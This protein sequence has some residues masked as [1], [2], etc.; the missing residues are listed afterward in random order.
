[1][2]KK[3]QLINRL[4]IY[5]I[6]IYSSLVASAPYRKQGRQRTMKRAC[7]LSCECS[8]W[9]GISNLSVFVSLHNSVCSKC[10]DLRLWWDSYISQSGGWKPESRVPMWP[11]F[12][13][14]SPPVGTLQNPERW[15]GFF[16]LPTCRTTSLPTPYLPA[17]WLQ[18]LL[19][20][21]MNYGGGEVVGQE[22]P[23]VAIAEN[24]LY[25]FYKFFSLWFLDYLGQGRQ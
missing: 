15:R 19:F 6:N 5:P 9:A 12:G 21:C 4:L 14:G 24:L 20:C 17:L 10:R 3:I 22:T 23:T 18:Q 7:P 1:M 8:G 2:G 25:Y 11:S 13:D 16:G